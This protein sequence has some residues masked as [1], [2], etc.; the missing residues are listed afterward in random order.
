MIRK[1]LFLLA[2]L[3]AVSTFAQQPKT[4]VLKASRIFDGTSDT[5]TANG[6]IVIEGNHIKS[7]GG[8]GP[9]NAQVID[10]GHGTLLPRLLDSHAHPTSQI[11]DNFY[12]DYF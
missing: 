7:I 2:A 8:A 10:L 5:V 3:F 9:A 4:I 6:V 12:D 1:S 11:G